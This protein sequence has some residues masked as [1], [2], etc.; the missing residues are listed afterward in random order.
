M[1]FTQ[2]EAVMIVLVYKYLHRLCYFSLLSPDL[3]IVSF[4]LNTFWIPLRNLCNSVYK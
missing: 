1:F 4:H 3:L 2:S